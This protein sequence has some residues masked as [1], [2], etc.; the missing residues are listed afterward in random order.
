[1]NP[2]QSLINPASVMPRRAAVRVAPTPPD[3]PRQKPGPK[4]TREPG[5]VVGQWTL[6]KRVHGTKKPRTNSGWLCRCSCGTEKFVRTDS[7]TKGQSTS[8]GHDRGERMSVR[9]SLYQA[10]LRKN[11]E[12]A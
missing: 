5:E 7:M 1:M 6:L 3:E 4:V 8:C 2:W 9:M 10:E 11:K 12:I